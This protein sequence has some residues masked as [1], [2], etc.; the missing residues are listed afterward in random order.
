[1]P[2]SVVGL[3][4][5]EPPVSDV[6]AFVFDAEVLEFLNDW[7]FQGVAILIEKVEMNGL[8]RLWLLW[9]TWCHVCQDED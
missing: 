4:L 6:V 9:L 5:A 3:T 1:M 8:L 2:C 7:L